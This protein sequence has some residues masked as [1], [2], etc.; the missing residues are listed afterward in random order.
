[1]IG[2][3]RLPQ[4]HQDWNRRWNAPFGDA[5]TELSVTQRLAEPDRE[6]FGPFAFQW[7]STTRILEYPWAYHAA[8]LEPGMRVLEVGGGLSGLQYVLDMEGCEVTNVD[9][10]A[11]ADDET[12]R[13]MP[14][15]GYAWTL[16][17]ANHASLNQAFGTGVR[18]VADRLQ[19]ADLPVGG[20]DR[21]L[22]LSV[23]EHLDAAEGRSLLRRIG[24]LLA[25]EGRCV[26]TIDLFL[27]LR[28]FGVRDRNVWGT[29][30]D[31]S[32]LVEGFEL[33]EGDRREL[34]GFPEFDLDHV[35]A[36]LP[37]LFVG[38]YPALSQTLVLRKAR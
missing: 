14:F 31:V 27:D 24:E 35:V 36:R 23:L 33:A 38:N 6:K 30:V 1:M 28:P 5:P 3:K 9:P 11:A 15:P 29:N 2:R 25:P 7:N 26:L 12:W 32:H 21:V 34:Y 22:C 10:S 16:T 8:E 20:F 17:P 13:A 37:E 18:L 19:D 4:S